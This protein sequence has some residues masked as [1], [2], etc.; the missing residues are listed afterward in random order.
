MSESRQRIEAM[1]KLLV[2]LRQVLEDL[3]MLTMLG[4]GQLV[5]QSHAK[6][7]FFHDLVVELQSNVVEIKRILVVAI[8]KD[9]NLAK[10]KQG[11]SP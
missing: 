3:K 11:K 8:A 6:P 4:E 9:V 5:L 2:S 7:G 10:L 1:R